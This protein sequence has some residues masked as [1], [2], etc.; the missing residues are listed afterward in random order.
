MSEKC[1]RLDVSEPYGPP[2]PVTGIASYVSGFLHTELLKLLSSEVDKISS[3][4]P[5]TIMHIGINT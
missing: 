4:N 5:K 1:E 3:N 2:L